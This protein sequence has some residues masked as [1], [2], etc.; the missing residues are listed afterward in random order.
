M[1]QRWGRFRTSYMMSALSKPNGIAISIRAQGR[2]KDPVVHGRLVPTSYCFVIV[3][4]P[5]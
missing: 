5:S 4:D 2:P 3:N 1:C